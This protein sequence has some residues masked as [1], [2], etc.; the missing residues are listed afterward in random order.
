MKKWIWIAAAA[1]YLV[2]FPPFHLDNAYLCSDK[3][4]TV[5]VVQHESVWD[6][7]GRYTVNGKQAQKLTEAIIEVNGLPADGSIRRGQK[8]KVPVLVKNLPP[9]MAEK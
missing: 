4:D 3:F 2:M 1:L 8:L 7:A 9:Q 5:T 6:I